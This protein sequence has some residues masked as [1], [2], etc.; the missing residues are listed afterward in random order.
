MEGLLT[1]GL[2]TWIHLCGLSFQHQMIG[3]LRGFR[4]LFRGWEYIH[5]QPSTSRPRIFQCS[6]F[7]KLVT[8][9]S[10]WPWRPWRLVNGFC[11]FC[12]FFW[13]VFFWLV[14]QL[15]IPF[16]E[17]PPK[18][19]AGKSCW[20]FRKKET[21]PKHFYAKTR[22][23]A[24]FLGVAEVL[25]FGTLHGEEPDFASQIMRAAAVA[26]GGGHLYSCRGFWSWNIDIVLMSDSFGDK[27][28]VHVYKWS[29]QI[30]IYVFFFWASPLKFWHSGRSCINTAG[31]H[32][33]YPRVGVS[34]YSS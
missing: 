34:P 2:P 7:V 4:I 24:S 20:D 32:G 30:I 10:S 21:T 8:G 6:V 23:L 25:N 15:L 5:V 9:H 27:F 29:F 14:A 19:M 3:A 26:F 33:D 22:P 28:Y 18:K 17:V 1:L 11:G 16:L 31:R 12:G 13:D